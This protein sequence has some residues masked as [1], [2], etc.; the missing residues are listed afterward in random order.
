MVSFLISTL[1]KGLLTVQLQPYDWPV[2]NI[3]FDTF[4]GRG[5]A[6][7]YVLLVLVCFVRCPRLS[8]IR[9]ALVCGHVTVI[10]HDIVQ[11]L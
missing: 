8:V 2:A 5:F 6:Y 9:Y 4:A 10:I 3:S 7:C 1:K 11:R